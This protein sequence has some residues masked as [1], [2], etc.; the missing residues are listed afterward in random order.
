MRR[1]CS[2]TLLVLG[3]WLLTSIAIVG[4]TP[5]DQGVSPWMIVGL[6]AAIAAPFLLIGT[7]M[8]PGRRWSE[9]GMTLMISAGVSAFIIVTLA[10]V[11]S[12]EA[13]QR[14]I[15]EPMPKFDFTAP[16]TVVAILLMGG[17]G[18]LLWRLGQ[19]RN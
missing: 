14:L 4:L 2:A 16:A 1:G 15:P 6:F 19:Q 17:G 3:G 18:Y 12:D 7:L 9:L 5:S 8:S 11:S 13:I 10:A